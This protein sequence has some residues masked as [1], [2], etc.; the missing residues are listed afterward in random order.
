MT[1]PNGPMH[2]MG[3][4]M[5]PR[6]APATHADHD[7]RIATVQPTILLS[8]GRYF[9]FR[10]PQPLT[11]EEVAHALSKLCR[12][13]G[14]CR[15]FYSVAQHSVHVSRLVP[16]HLALQGLLHDAVEAVLGDMS[17]PLKRLFPEYK[18]LEHRVEAV[19]LQG[20]GLPAQLDPL[21]KHADLVA[22]RTEQ[23]DLMH[24]EGG[25]WTCLDGIEPDSATIYPWDFT[26][27][28]KLEFL[29]RYAELTGGNARHF[30]PDLR[31]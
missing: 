6:I 20:F 19:I 5:P 2:E 1:H 21:V 10:D 12:F 17:G 13:T 27:T 24:K 11:I 18:A 25:L 15:R 22:L 26:V 29:D 30:W 8:S 16:P 3:D 23:R 14:Q 7:A 31:S 4:A 28:A 9:D